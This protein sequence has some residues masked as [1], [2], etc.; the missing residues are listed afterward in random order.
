MFPTSLHL[1]SPALQQFN[2]K[3]TEAVDYIVSS[4]TQNTTEGNW[5]LRL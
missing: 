1:T 2:Q 5:I 3:L 4:G